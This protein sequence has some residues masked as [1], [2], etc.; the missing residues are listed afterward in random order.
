MN[1]YI[2]EIKSRVAGIPCTI[3]VTAWEP[4]RPGRLYGPPEDCYPDEGGYGEWDVLIRGRRAH[5]LERKLTADDV[6]RID[7]E[8]FSAHRNP[9]SSL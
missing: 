9:E 8:L 5:W 2:F 7:D 4:Y 1:G 6:Q 3:G